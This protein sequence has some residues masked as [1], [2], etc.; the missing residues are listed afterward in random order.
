M[1]LHEPEFERA[2]KL[3]TL[4]LAA[5]VLTACGARTHVQYRDDTAK[6]LGQREG[7]IKSCYDAILKKDTSARG[8]VTVRFVVE[9]T[10][11]LVK[12]TQIN[13]RNTTAST[14]LAKCVSGALD[15]LTLDPPDP[16]DGRAT[17]TFVLE[18]KRKKAAKPAVPPEEPKPK[19]DDDTDDTDDPV[20]KS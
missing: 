13:S 4:L 19:A 11:G 12:D 6:L 18:A 16:L 10:T 5:F 15:G 8:K 17:F 9:A 2:T 1:H 20:D 3:L 14:D 7:E